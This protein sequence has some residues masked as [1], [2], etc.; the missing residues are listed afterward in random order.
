MAQAKSSA[1]PV[2]HYDFRVNHRLKLPQRGFQDQWSQPRVTEHPC[3]MYWSTFDHKNQPNVTQYIIH[4]RG[5]IYIFLLVNRNMFLAMKWLLN[6]VIWYIIFNKRVAER[7]FNAGIL[8]Q[9]GE[10]TQIDKGLPA[11]L[12]GMV[13]PSWE[14]GPNPSRI[15][16]N[17]RVSKG[18]PPKTIIE[19]HQF[20]E[21]EA[22]GSTLTV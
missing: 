22:L 4:G 15:K 9:F 12:S 2:V 1:S 14:D 18:N 16:R 11:I 7:Q 10:K 13:Q 6:V 19:Y 20:L 21:L 8:F 5:V 3:M 17:Q